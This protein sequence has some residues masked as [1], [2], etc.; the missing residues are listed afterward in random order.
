MKPEHPW[1]IVPSIWNK[2]LCIIKYQILNWAIFPWNKVTDT[3]KLEAP[4]IM[5][6]V[7]VNYINEFS[8]GNEW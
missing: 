2:N 1:M 7:L 5:L 3:Q 8:H 4:M 6:S